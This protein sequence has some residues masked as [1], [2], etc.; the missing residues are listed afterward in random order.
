MSGRGRYRD[1][2]RKERILIAAADLVAKHGYHSVSMSDIG[3]AAGIV[4]SG[5]YRH[6]D[7]KA[8]V[9]VALLDRVMQ[10]LLHNASQIVA[11][12]GDTRTALASLV[13]DQVAFAI[14]DR[15]L[16]QVYQREIHNLPAEDRRRLRRM[17]RRYIQQWVQVVTALRPDTSDEEIHT[18]VHAAIG[19]IQST[20][21]F[22]SGIP[23]DRLTALLSG[24]AHA[25]LRLTPPPECL[26]D[27]LDKNRVNSLF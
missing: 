4:G 12:A 24:A 7:S 6:F 23:A 19:A 18:A 3:A 15:R 1:P 13:R 10:R 17:Q 16:V 11:D 20:V 22:R 8:A 14:E 25:C 26:T 9:L 2:A 5:I 21:F 27:D